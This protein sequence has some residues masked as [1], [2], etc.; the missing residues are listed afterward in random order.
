MELKFFLNIKKDKKGALKD[1]F[2]KYYDNLF[3]YA[4]LF[5][6]DKNIADEIVS[7][8]FTDL[9]VKR[10]TIKIKTNFSAYLYKSTKNKAL[11]FLRK[12][13]LDFYN[14]DGDDNN[15]VEDCNPEKKVIRLEQTNKVENI[16]DLIPPRSREVFTLHR[17][18]NLKYKEIAELLGI[19]K[20]TVENH[21]V[22]ALKILRDYYKSIGIP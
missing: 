9:W 18:D 17:F 14:I 8:V 15:Y 3:V 4:N 12:K 22:K 20:N 6:Q 2:D 5:L 21:I 1:L 10:K 13:K 16:L 19:S 11:S 7:D